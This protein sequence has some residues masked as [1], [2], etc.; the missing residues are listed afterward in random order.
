M[1]REKSGSAFRNSGNEGYA[2]SATW[3]GWTMGAYHGDLASV[4]RPVGR[5][6]L[7]YND[8][9]KRDMNALDI[10][11]QRREDM[12]ADRDSWRSMLQIQL[13]AG[14]EQ[15]QMLAEEKRARSTEVDLKTSHTCVRCGKVFLSRIGLF[16]PSRRC[17]SRES[18][19]A[20]NCGR[21]IHGRD[22][23]HSPRA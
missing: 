17:A 7:R 16:S 10:N 11:I 22:G 18:T 23:G 5:S 20:F 4:K 15:I 12:A 14:E 3:D 13:K 1:V 2:G 19:T 9:C 6:Q 8:L 21:I